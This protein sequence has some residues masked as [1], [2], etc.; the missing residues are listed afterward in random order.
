VVDEQ[1]PT[2]RLVNAAACMAAAVGL[3]IP[4]LGGRD[5]VDASGTRR[6]GLPWA[7]CSIVAADSATSTAIRTAA[8]ER[9]NDLLLADM[10]ELA[11]LSR[12]YDEYVDQLAIPNKKT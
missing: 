9:S 10:P 1:M 12:V 4:G 2:G 8:Q 5:G 3:A 11:Q 7:G 6:L